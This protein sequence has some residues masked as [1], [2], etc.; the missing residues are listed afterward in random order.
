MVLKASASSDLSRRIVT[1]ALMDELIKGR[2]GGLAWPV[3]KELLRR[4]YTDRRR[5]EGHMKPTSI[6]AT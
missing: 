2:A 1:S 4:R 6:G 3:S 5:R